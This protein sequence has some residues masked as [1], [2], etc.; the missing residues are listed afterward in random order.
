MAGS[1]DASRQ[2]VM[3]V[4]DDEDVREAM[5]ELLKTAGYLTLEAGNGKE[6]I[7]VLTKAQRLPMLILLDLAM[8]ILDG[9]GFLRLRARDPLLREIPVFVV[10]ASEPPALTEGIEIFLCKPVEVTRLLQLIGQYRNT[11]GVRT[12]AVASFDIKTVTTV[13]TP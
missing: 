9:F 11:A 3:L 7:E 6:A 10:S 4:D 8:P 2:I 13:P 5:S 12:T 1:N